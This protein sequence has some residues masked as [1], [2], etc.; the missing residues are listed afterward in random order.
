MAKGIILTEDTKSGYQFVSKLV[1][2]IFGDFYEVHNAVTLG[3]SQSGGVQSI[4][5][6]LLS[7]EFTSKYANTPV[8]VMFDTCVE[9]EV[10]TS[11]IE[12]I[13]DLIDELNYYSIDIRCFEHMMLSFK[14]LPYWCNTQTAIDNYRIYETSLSKYGDIKGYLLGNAT[15]CKSMGINTNSLKNAEHTYAEIL[16]VVTASSTFAIQSK[17]ISPCWL[18]DCCIST[19]P[20]I[21]SYPQWKHLNLDTYTYK[22]CGFKDTQTTFDY[23][24]YQIA[25]FGKSLWYDVVTQ[26]Q[27]YCSKNNENT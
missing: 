19:Q 23:K 14:D 21:A 1:E 15:L 3:I 27:S 5:K 2:C 10:N 26:L 4:K 20:E 12:E 17:N 7:S 24:V 13:I 22:P 18:Y 25:Q 8:V 9:D 6:V 11:I 16:R